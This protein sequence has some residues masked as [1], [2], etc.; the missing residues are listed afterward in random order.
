MA[1]LTDHTFFPSCAHPFCA[2]PELA[3]DDLIG[4]LEV[5]LRRVTT[6][7]AEASPPLVDIAHGTLA[8]LARIR[9]ADRLE[10]ISGHVAR[11][12]RLCPSD[13]QARTREQR[14]TFVRQLAM[15]LCRKISWAQE[16]SQALDAWMRERTVSARGES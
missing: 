3:A 12:F 13:L 11:D 8:A 7:S 2:Q 15:F 16:S 9:G 4:P 10:R 5:V 1:E 14:I 6:L